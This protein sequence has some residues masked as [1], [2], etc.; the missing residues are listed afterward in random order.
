[1]AQII[2]NQASLNYEYNGQTASV[3]SNVAT[4]TLG[5]AISVEKVSLE[6]NYRLGSE[7]T[8]SV[9]FLNSSGS[10][11][12]NVTISDDLGAYPV[13]GTSAV[14]LSY[15]APAIL[16]IDGV[17]A[18]NITPT[19]GTGIS[20]TVP[21][22]AAGS[23]AQIV[24]RAAANNYAPLS[25]GGTVTNTVTVRA[26]GLTGSVSDSDTVAA[27]SYADVTVTKTMSPQNVL[28]GDAIT[29]TFVINNYGN[30]PATNIV[31]SDAFDPAPENISLQV[32][33]ATVA[34]ENYT[35]VGGVLTFPSDGSAYELS[36]P[37]A[38]ITSDPN[39]GLV[40]VVP[41]TVTV[42]VVGVI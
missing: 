17:Y 23:R 4:A 6:D 41:S 39:S 38:E 35:Y 9:S 8:Y 2:T 31:L 19:I 18:G 40:T 30:A 29:Y 22:L 26:D 16:F 27:D 5:E 20:F 1:M 12:T 28:D 15:L 36:L 7:I 37:A 14:P 3:L 21:S 32:N 42:T 33:G 25:E 11:L 10:T 24:Y 34:P 13:G